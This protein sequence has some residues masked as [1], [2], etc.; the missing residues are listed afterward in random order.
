[1]LSLTL[2]NKKEN[3]QSKNWRINTSLHT[4]DRTN[5]RLDRATELNTF[6]NMFSSE[7]SSASPAH[8]QSDIPSSFDPQL[9]CHTSNV[10]SST[11]AM[12]PS[13]STCLPSTKSEDADAPVVPPS[14]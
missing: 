1:M 13:A 5:G 6:F 12:D 9:S 2:V 14:T 10:L 4:D 8:N 3:P 11:S 7:T